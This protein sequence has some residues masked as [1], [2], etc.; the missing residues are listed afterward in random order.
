M[1]KIK[2]VFCVNDL[3]AP[4]NGARRRRCIGLLRG[5]LGL[6]HAA[7]AAFTGRLASHTVSA[8]S[9]HAGSSRRR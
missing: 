2:L 6:T 1:S 3:D 8:A 5:P 7:A 4:T 9:A